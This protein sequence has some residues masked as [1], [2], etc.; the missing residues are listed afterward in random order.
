MAQ[1][2]REGGSVYCVL[3]A[4]F[5]RNFH[6]DTTKGADASAA[7]Y[8]IIETAK[9]NGLHIFTYLEYLCLT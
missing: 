4:Q 9:A 5:E 3:Y 6:T 7:V 1:S 2:E 8:S